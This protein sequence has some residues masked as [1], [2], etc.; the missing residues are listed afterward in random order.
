MDA[1]VSYRADSIR[2]APAPL[3]SGSVKVKLE[4]GLLTADPLTFDLPQ[5][6]IS[7]SV[8]LNARQATPVTDLDLRLSNARLEQ[9]LPT[10]AGG[11][12]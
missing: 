1:N 6:R 12:R 11:Q 3:R 5:G 7:G 4:R 9:L 2:D 8:S 10:M